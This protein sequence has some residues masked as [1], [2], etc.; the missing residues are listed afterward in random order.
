[1]NKQ[2]RENIYGAIIYLNYGKDF[3]D[4][5]KIDDIKFLLNSVKAR[6]E[7]LKRHSNIDIAAICLV[8][9]II[10]NINRDRYAAEPELLVADIRSLSNF[11]P[12]KINLSG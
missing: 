1:M 4:W 6:L 7:S 3:N 2:D 11:I 9:E 5:S 8:D 12:E 10:E